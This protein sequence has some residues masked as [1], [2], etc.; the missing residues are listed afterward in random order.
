MS[1][2]NAEVAQSI[3][4]TVKP[5]VRPISVDLLDTDGHEKLEQRERTSSLALSGDDGNGVLSGPS[6]SGARGGGTTDAMIAKKMQEQATLDAMLAKNRRSPWALG[7]SGFD[8]PG[9]QEGKERGGDSCQ[10]SGTD[11]PVSVRSVQSVSSKQAPAK[12]QQQQQQQQLDLSLQTGFFPKQ[13]RSRNQSGHTTP[14]NAQA[15]GF[16]TSFTSI[17]NDEEEK[18]ILK[19]QTHR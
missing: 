13:Q 19:A 11:S 14:S 12:R 10:R 15:Y 18:T 6:G 16:T 1:A 8:P 5:S 2:A 7:S 17:L 9:I 4:M 3:A